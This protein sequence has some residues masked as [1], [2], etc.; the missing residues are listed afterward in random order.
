VASFFVIL[1]CGQLACALIFDHYGAF[2]F[3][4]VSIKW[5]RVFGALV[6]VIGAALV[7]SD[8]NLKSSFSRLINVGQ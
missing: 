5:Y 4:E 3:E 7:S 1:I 6:A 2:H 8:F